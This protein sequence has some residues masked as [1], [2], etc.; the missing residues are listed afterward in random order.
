MLPAA[1]LSDEPVRIDNLPD[2][3]DVGTMTQLLSAIGAT[4]EPA[5]P[6]AVTVMPTD[7]RPHAV[8]AD[9]ATQMRASYY[10]LG[11]LLAR[12]GEAVVP[13]PGGCDI[14]ARPIDQ[15]IKGFRALG[16]EVEVAHGVIS[17]SARRLR[18]AHVY[19]DVTSVGA[20]I[21]LMMAAA[22]AEGTTIIENAAKEPHVVDVATL[23]LAMGGSIV[24]AGTDVIKVR[25]RPRLG[26]CQHAIIPDEIEAATFMIAVGA[27]SGDVTVENVIPRHLEPISAKLVEAG[28]R[29][30]EEGD[31][32]RVVATDRPQAIRVKTLP[33]PGFPTDAQQPMTSMLTIAA[34]ISTVTENIWEGRFRF[35]EELDRMGARITVSGRTA[36]IEGVRRLRGAAVT[37]SDLRAGA[38]L[39]IAGLIA[40]GETVVGGIEHLDR[41]Y[42][43][44]DQKLR[45]LGAHIERSSGGS[46]A[47]AA[48]D[49]GIT[50]AQG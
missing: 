43:P 32:V 34:G 4:V 6:N 35:T 41:G 33:Y 12:C 24:G 9:L 45:L 30:E 31:A 2:I 26:G 42:E 15:H 49:G 14:G 22:L 5:G 18:G 13:F 19:L 11:V 40:D 46:R 23:L 8:P 44:I 47:F 7:F 3:G 50:A 10:L 1:L 21:N 48:A 25:G 37:A 27:A 38:A 20:T 17:A 36:T 28:C 39:V 16:A 29:V